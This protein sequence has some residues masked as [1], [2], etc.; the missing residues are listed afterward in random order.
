MIKLINKVNINTTIYRCLSLAAILSL[1]SC[2]G[3]G[4]GDCPDD[5]SSP[6][7]NRI[8]LQFIVSEESSVTRANPVGGEDGNGREDE[9]F[10][11]AKIH[12][13]NIFLFAD[14]T[15]KLLNAAPNTTLAH[16][17]FNLDDPGDR[18]NSLSFEKKTSEE[19]NK[20]VYTVT[21]LDEVPGIVLPLRTQGTVRFITVA[22]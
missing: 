9:I 4:V 21:F 5:V 22:N 10:N 2:I 7:E 11:E 3:E 13:V 16:L 12:D 19:N 17:Y 20:T 6:K 1:S 14:N 8:T 15:P 18:E